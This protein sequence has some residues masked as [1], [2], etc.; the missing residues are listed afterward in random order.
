MMSVIN[1]S[2]KEEMPSVGPT[3]PSKTTD[4]ISLDSFW[5]TNNRYVWT[6]SLETVS[7]GRRPV[8]P[9]LTAAIIKSEDEDSSSSRNK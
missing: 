1:V 5:I 8:V 7:L 3:G 6:T 2:Q 9:C 4:D